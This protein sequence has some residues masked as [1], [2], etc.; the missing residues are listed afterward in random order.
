MGELNA[1]ATKFYVDSE[2]TNETVVVK[3]SDLSV[4]QRIKTPLHPTHITLTRDGSK[5]IVM[6][7][8][9]GTV[10]FIDPLQDQIIKV[11]G[12]FFLPHFGRM[13]LD[14]KSVYVANLHSNHVT[15]VDLDTLTIADYIPL[16]GFQAPPNNIDLDHEGG[17]ADVQI[18]QVTGLLY[19]AHRDTG[20]VLVYD[21]NK[22][23]KVAEL[24]VGKQPWI[25]YAEH[26]FDTVSRRH[27]VPNFADETASIIS[28]SINP[29]VLAT[30]GIADQ[31]SFGVNY[32]PLAPDQAFLMNRYKQQIQVVDTAKMQPLD[33]IDVGGT[34]ETAS[35]SAD[36]KYIVATVS[37]ANRVVIIDAATHKI[38][39]TFDNV[40][41][42]PWSVTM[43]GGQNYC[44]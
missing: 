11:L 20:K 34:T 4:V 26:P 28:D 14:G 6:N 13:A 24:Q 36:G 15:R 8:G 10:T 7:E 32:S 21:T 5:F 44:H 18:D 40:G 41:T 22:Q 25:V 16:D 43:F 12:G 1:D 38:L 9:A 3:T 19:G 42:Y 2:E 30:L 27:M 33:T 23:Q 37:S 29:T 31:E 17:F 39:K 35:T